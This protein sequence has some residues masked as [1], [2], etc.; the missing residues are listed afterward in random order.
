MQWCLV[1][2]PRS[3]ESLG[4]VIK[5]G[6]RGSLCAT[7]TVEG[8]QG[9]VPYP[10]LAE[11]P[12]HHLAPALAEL[13]AEQWDNGNEFFPPTSWQVSNINSGT[14]AENVIPGQVDVQ[15]NLRFS[16]ELTPDQIKQRVHAIFDAY[17][18]KYSIQW[19]LSGN[20]FLTDGGE[21]VTAAQAVLEELPDVLPNYRPQE[22]LLT[23]GL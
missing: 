16:T 17:D 12:I 2:E 11:N 14:G 13:V 5:V 23:G 8:I 15:F 3:T 1:G 19:R 4:D 18:L 21:L 22:V 20:P 10:H 9:H 6:R 7:M